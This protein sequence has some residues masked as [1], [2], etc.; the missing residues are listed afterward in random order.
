LKNVTPDIL[1]ELQEEAAAQVAPSDDPD[2]A[3]ILPHDIALDPSAWINL[4]VHFSGMMGFSTAQIK[5][6][7]QDQGYKVL[8]PDRGITGIFVRTTSVQGKYSTSVFFNPNGQMVTGDQLQ[9]EVFNQF[10][11]SAG[12]PNAI[13][14]LFT[15][16]RTKNNQQVLEVA[17][18]AQ[19]SSGGAT[20]FLQK[21]LEILNKILK[22]LPVIVWVGIGAAVLFVGWQVGKYIRDESKKKSIVTRKMERTKWR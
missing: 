4:R 15:S 7:L 9:S 12:A 8:A 19:E 10:G 5:Q 3:I 13:V 18:Q 21:L 11:V 1:E 20:D 14:S 16:E 2:N 22:A 17:W 6:L